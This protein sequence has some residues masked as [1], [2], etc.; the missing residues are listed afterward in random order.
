MIENNVKYRSIEGFADE[1]LNFLNEDK[2]SPINT[3]EFVP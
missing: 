1:V 2:C 3:I